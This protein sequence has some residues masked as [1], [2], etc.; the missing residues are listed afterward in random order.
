MYSVRVCTTDDRELPAPELGLGLGWDRLTEILRREVSPGAA[1]LLAEPIAEPARGQTHWHIQANEDPRVVSEL[2]PAEREKV[3]AVLA[4]QRSAILKL[5]DRLAAD[6]SETNSRLA[7][8]LRVIVDVP[9]PDRHIWSVGGQPVLSA[10][11]RSPVTSR[12]QRATIVARGQAPKTDAVQLSGVVT[13]IAPAF[14]PTKNRT[15]GGADESDGFRLR[16]LNRWRNLPLWLL[17]AAI[18]LTILYRL[19][20]ACGIDL[21]LLRHFSGHCPAGFAPRAESAFTRLDR[22]GRIESCANR[23]GLRAAPG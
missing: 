4:K 6:G 5:A 12:E 7:S 1:S 16:N 17:L 21:P 10:W 13:G 11:G 19:L 14:D 2:D 23:G 3:L 22:C 8:A 9:D 18:L 20:P 15:R